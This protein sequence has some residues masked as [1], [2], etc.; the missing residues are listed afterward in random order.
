MSAIG[1]YIH[2]YKRNYFSY[3]TKRTE[4]SRTFGAVDFGKV[5]TDKRRSMKESFQVAYKDK[6]KEEYQSTLNYLYGSSVL[7]GEQLAENTEKE[8][9]EEFQKILQEKFPDIIIDY[10]TFSVVSKDIESFGGLKKFNLKDSQ[11]SFGSIERKIQQLKNIFQQENLKNRYSEQELIKKQQL[12]SK[13]VAMEKSLYEQAK[14]KNSWNKMYVRLG[15]VSK[16]KGFGINLNKANKKQQTFI[17]DLNQ[18][19]DF[20]NG[21]KKSNINGMLGEL[22][23]AVAGAKMTGVAVSNL[24]NYLTEAIVGNQT[25]YSQYVKV[26]FS[27]EFVDMEKLAT[28]GWSYNTKDGNVTVSKPTQDK[29]DIKITTPEGIKTLS[30]KNYNLRRGNAQISLV[31]GMSLLSIIQNENQ[32]DFI[33]HYFNITSSRQGDKNLYYVATARTQMHQLMRD[34]ILV[35]ALTGLN[36]SK[37]MKGGQQAKKEQ[38]VAD[39]FVINDNS[40][41]GKFK[42]YSMSELL[43][44]S[45]FSQMGGLSKFV[46][47]RGYDDPEWTNEG[48]NARSRIS[49]LIMQTHRMKLHAFASSKFFYQQNNNT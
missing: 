46:T 25:S 20:V 11:L 31:T 32:E 4:G 45:S 30:V 39:Y 23:A 42:I 1:E 33:N 3:G 5:I 8:L 14:L 36:I 49:N 6:F 12:L 41:P 18:L 38:T 21:V 22:S 48:D 29:V 34:I 28:R 37:T 44:F 17:Q 40:Q 13:V 7:Q 35:N 2:Y 19:I 47:V 43:D 10:S 27:D 15:N 26:N 9:K 24:R 16:S